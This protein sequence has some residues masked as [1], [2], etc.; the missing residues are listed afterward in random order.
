[1]TRCRALQEKQNELTGAIVGVA[2]VADA[3]DRN[4]EAA[5]AAADAAIDAA[6][7]KLQNRRAGNLSR[8]L[9]FSA[10]GKSVHDLT[11]SSSVYAWRDTRNGSADLKAS[12]SA[13]HTEKRRALDEQKRYLDRCLVRFH[14]AADFGQLL[15]EQV[16]WKHAVNTRASVTHSIL[17]LCVHSSRWRSHNL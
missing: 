8:G 5:A 17:P 12:I 14:T 7:G 16:R 15:L 4:A 9:F 10:V 11:V 3:L 2:N 1:M 13:V 6:I